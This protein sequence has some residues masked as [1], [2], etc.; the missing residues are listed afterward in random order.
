MMALWNQPLHLQDA[1][2]NIPHQRIVLHLRSKHVKPME[3]T[4]RKSLL[5]ISQA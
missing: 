2:M 4:V 1:I 5:I 3:I